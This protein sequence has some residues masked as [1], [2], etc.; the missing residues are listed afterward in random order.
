MRKTIDTYSDGKIKTEYVYPNKND[1]S[2][3]NIIDYYNNGKVSFKGTVENNKFIGVKLS[4][5]ETG[6][7]REVDSISNPCDFDICCCDGKVF[8]YYN[9]GKL[10]EKFEN[11]NGVANGLVFIYGSD[12]SGK[13]WQ[14]R[15]YTDDKQN[16]ITK[17][18]Y[19]SGKLY[20]V[21]DFKNDTLIN[22]VFY[23]RENGDTMKIL[24][25]RKGKEDFPVKKWL[26]N[27]QIFYAFH[28]DSY[29][30]IV[31]RWTDSIGRELKREIV[32]SKTGKE[33]LTSN[34]KFITPN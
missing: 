8:R 14:I 10:D 4:Y 21:E 34:G 33:W 25:I 7:L 26:M 24:S 27:G 12:S 2:K 30:G 15:N 1:E 5:Y 18:F 28:L 17:T 9:N 6:N 16:G 20:K 22:H 19:E 29:N 23:F 3:Y 13:V 11:K 31:Y 32:S